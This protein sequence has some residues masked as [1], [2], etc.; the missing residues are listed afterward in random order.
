MIVVAAVSGAIIASRPATPRPAAE[1]WTFAQSHADVYRA[2]SPSLEP[3]LGGSLSVRLIP[4][5]ALNVRLV[6][7]IMADRA[8]DDLPDVVEIRQDAIG[9]YLS[10]PADHVGLLPLDEFLDRPTT[11]GPARSKLIA[12]RLLPYTKD[13]RVFGIPRDVHPVALCYRADLFAEADVD[14]ESPT[15]GLDHVSWADFQQRCLQFQAYWR[16]RGVADRWAL[17][18]FS[19]NADLLTALL[20]QRGVSLI[21]AN[22]GVRLTDPV[23]AETLRFYAGLVAG[24]G[25]ISADSVSAGRNVWAKDLEAG[26]VCAVIAP[27]WRIADLKSAAPSLAGRWR[28]TRL[29]RFNPADAPTTTWGGTMVAIPRRCRDPEKSWRIVESLYL[30]DAANAAQVRSLGILPASAALGPQASAVIDSQDAYFTGPSPLRTYAE[31]APAIPPQVLTPDSA[32]ATAALGY[33]LSQTV[34]AIRD[35]AVDDAT[36][37]ARIA[38][39]LAPRKTD[40]ERQIAHG[41]LAMD[42]PR[43]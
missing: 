37:Q 40:V 12:R 10:P 17:D 23:V 41:R 30:S 9:R 33:V 13:G 16:S 7:L 31:L 3:Q 27:D 2:L 11:G 26:V 5:N 4:N 34:G 36:L 18:L 43:P 15:P 29:P 22:H 21:D 28:V 6:S 38:D 35:G 39:W 8:G 32:Y 20:L 19:A 25:R 1:L 42:G 14:L 24:P